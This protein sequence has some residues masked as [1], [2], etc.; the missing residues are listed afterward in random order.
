MIYGGNAKREVSLEEV[1]RGRQPEM[2]ELYEAIKRTT[3]QCLTMAAG[4]GA[5]EVLFEHRRVG[6]TGKDTVMKH[7]MPSWE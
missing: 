4:A 3:V 7:Q 2:T 6:K 1:M 5:L